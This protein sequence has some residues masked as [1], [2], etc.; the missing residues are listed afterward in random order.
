MKT[1]NF[2]N[3]KGGV[4]K[5]VIAA[6]IAS[7]LAR[8]GYRVLIIDLDSQCDITELFLNLNPSG[9]G[10]SKKHLNVH[11]V[12]E[13]ECGIEKAYEKVG[14]N[15]YLLP[16]SPNIESFTLKFSQKA[17]R[18]KLRSKGLSKFNYVIIDNPPS[19]TPAV[20]CGLVA[21]DY[22][23]VVT[24]AENPAI[25]NLTKLNTQIEDLRKKLNPNLSVLGIALN[26]IDQRR[27]ITKRNVKKLQQ[28]FPDILFE[29]LIS[30]DTSVPN[31]IDQRITIRDL[32]WRSR[33]VT[34]LQRLLDEILQRIDSKEGADGI[35][36]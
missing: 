19:I 4:G 5:T 18:D 33:T 13:N 1:L 31:S 36:R 34:Q 21:S 12:L 3:R 7:E 9:K 24:E 28:L 32:H 30:I 22:I 14:E 2:F 17:L 16:G 26:K 25:N 35:S 11:N 6:N 20:V 23:V 10:C 27:N 15:L 29:N 8:K